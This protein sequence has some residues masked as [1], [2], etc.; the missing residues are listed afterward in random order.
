[1]RKK[2]RST[3]E[4]FRLSDDYKERFIKKLHSQPSGADKK[5]KPVR[6][7]SFVKVA[8]CAAMVALLAL[9]Y[10]RIVRL[11]G[12][13][14]EVVDTGGAISLSEGVGETTAEHTQTPAALDDKLIKATDVMKNVFGVDF[15]SAFSYKSD[16]FT[17][18]YDGGDKFV[19]TDTGKRA[20]KVRIMDLDQSTVKDRYEY[21]DKGNNV[22]RGAIARE[23]TSGAFEDKIIYSDYRDEYNGI[24]AHTTNGEISGDIYINKGSR[25]ADGTYTALRYE[26]VLSGDGRV[27]LISAYKTI[28]S[29][30][31]LELEKIKYTNATTTYTTLSRNAGIEKVLRNGVYEYTKWTFV[32]GSDG[33]VR[34]G[35]GRRNHTEGVFTKNLTASEETDTIFVT[36]L[37]FD[38]EGRV[39][40]K[41]KKNE[42]FL[43]IAIS[44][45]AISSGS[46]TKTVYDR[47]TVTITETGGGYEYKDVSIYNDKNQPID[48]KKEISHNGKTI[49]NSHI[50]FEYN[51]RGDE[52]KFVGTSKR[53]SSDTEDDNSVINFVS[54]STWEYN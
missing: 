36:E 7:M 29:D 10:V 27:Y 17:L 43:D 18:E 22:R 48:V 1:M 35:V 25:N 14:G 47:N 51:E 16:Y 23:S 54:I 53:S 20:A 12:P 37:E 28:Y 8:A 41:T 5:R 26:M 52:I 21:D 31:G 2:Y 33:R 24:T 32:Y 13:R 15:P 4:S 42:Y 11:I 44:D 19:L 39:V 38:S 40:L 45:I 50:T 49:S 9:G 3:M 34:S 30:D 46:V 6:I